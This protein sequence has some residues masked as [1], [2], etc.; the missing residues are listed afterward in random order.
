[1]F[2]LFGGMSRDETRGLVFRAVLVL[3]GLVA[4]AAAAGFLLGWRDVLRVWPFLGYGLTPVFL[5]SILAAI[6]A[7]VIW[8]GLTGEFAALRGGA[9]NLLVSAGGIAAYALS[10]SWGDP[11]GRVQMFGILHLAVA[12]VALLLLVASQR[13]EWR[14]DRPTPVLV[15][16]SFAIF[17]LTLVGVGTALVLR[18]DVFPWPLDDDTSI[19]YGLIFLGA[20]VYFAYGLWRPVWGN[21]KGQLVGFLAYDLVLIVP[22]VRLWPASPSLSLAVYLAVIAA[23]GLLAIWYLALSPRYRLW[24]SE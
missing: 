19:V 2:D 9:A 16:I 15:R 7:P 21:A 1:M 22:F 4:L 11:A 23:S 14:D 18:L 17:G 24:A 12:M 10:Q 3:A 8:I 20:A 13:A 5:A 6:A